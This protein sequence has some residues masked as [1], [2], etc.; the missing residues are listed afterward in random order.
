MASQP[1]VFVYRAIVVS[2]VTDAIVSGRLSCL[3]FLWVRTMEFWSVG[4]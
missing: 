3:I 1:I 2:L 4:A